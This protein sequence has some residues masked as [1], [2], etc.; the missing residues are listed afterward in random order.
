MQKEYKLKYPLEVMNDTKGEFEKK[1]LLVI[2]VGGFSDVKA[3][4]GYQDKVF[5]VFMSSVKENKDTADKKDTLKNDK[6]DAETMLAVLEME[7]TSE[8]MFDMSF[9][10]IK[11][12]GTIG[13]QK[14]S[15]EL[16]DQMSIEDMDML[17]EKVMKDFLSKKAILRLNNMSK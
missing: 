5:K 8:E 9:D 12:C 1:D 3:L 16:I 17:Y 11:R 4:K 6:L 15:A 2:K 14:V 10:L 7:G 13:E